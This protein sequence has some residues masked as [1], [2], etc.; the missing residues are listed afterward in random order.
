M[1]YNAGVE[2]FKISYDQSFYDKLNE[3]KDNWSL[4]EG[5]RMPCGILIVIICYVRHDL[6]VCDSDIIGKCFEEGDLILDLSSN[7]YKGEEM[8]D[9]RIEQ[10]FKVVN[11]INLAGKEAVELGI[12]AKVIEKEEL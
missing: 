8:A 4:V 12:K 5:S 2:R 10:L 3:N 9:E 6:A 1:A 7:F 11:I